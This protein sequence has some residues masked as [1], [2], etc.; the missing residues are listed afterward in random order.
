[1]SKE[2]H[3]KARIIEGFES[4][5]EAWQRTQVQ[6][7]NTSK[8]SHSPRLENI[9]FGEHDEATLIAEVNSYPNRKTINWSELARKYKVQHKNS[10]D[11]IG[12][13]GQVI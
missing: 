12:N 6:S 9:R 11:V 7:N 2:Q 5:Q 8:K 10:T 4:V 3:L 1:M 13:G